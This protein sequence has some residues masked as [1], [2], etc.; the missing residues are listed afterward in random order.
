M[1]KGK[2]TIVLNMISINVYFGYNFK[3]FVT[4][5]LSIRD[6]SDFFF[7]SFLSQCVGKKACVSYSTTV[8]LSLYS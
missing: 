8:M 2:T 4:K 6:Y 7:L 3:F 1:S 5:I